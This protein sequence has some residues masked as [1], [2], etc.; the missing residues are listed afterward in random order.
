MASGLLGSTTK[1]PHDA[2]DGQRSPPHNWLDS[3]DEGSATVVAEAEVPPPAPAEP[4]H[5]LSS[6]AQL[7]WDY[8]LAHP[9]SGDALESCHVEYVA[10][11]LM[12]LQAAKK[13]TLTSQA[14][15]GKFAACLFI[16]VVQEILHF[17]RPTILGFSAEVIHR[18]MI[19]FARHVEPSVLI[20]HVQALDNEGAAYDTAIQPG[21]MDC[22]YRENGITDLLGT[23]D[24]A[25]GDVAADAFDQRGVQIEGTG[26]VV[27]SPPAQRSKLTRRMQLCLGVVLTLTTLYAASWSPTFSSD[28]ADSLSSNW[29]AVGLGQQGASAT[30]PPPATRALATLCIFGIHAPC[31]IHPAPCTAH[32]RGLSIVPCAMY[33]VPCTIRPARLTRAVRGPRRL[34][35]AVNNLAQL[36]IVVVSLAFLALMFPD[37]LDSREARRYIGI[38]LCVS[39]ICDTYVIIGVTRAYTATR[40]AAARVDDDRHMCLLIHYVICAFFFIWGVLYPT[41]VY[42]WMHNSWARLRS[43][44]V[45]DAAVFLTA[46]AALWYYGEDKFPPGDAPLHV[47]LLGRPAICLLASATFGQRNRQRL[48]AWG[49]RLGLFHV[50]VRASPVYLH[51]SPMRLPSL[52][53]VCKSVNL[54][55]P[56][57]SILPLSSL[58]DV[59][60]RIL[61]HVCQVGLNELR[62]GEIRRMLSKSGVGAPEADGNSALSDVFST[63]EDDRCAI[64]HV[65]PPFHGLRW[66]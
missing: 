49:A 36:L 20:Q 51:A 58:I 19:D 38:F 37:D 34:P 44:L 47:A 59:L 64:S 32:P 33:H 61:T 48:V 21:F 63:P 45:V 25:E 54:P 11:R 52:F 18:H 39:D 43:G 5:E 10:G 31:T 66:L 65:S 23:V 35:S 16:L 3:P 50:Q 42:F 27:A 9:L 41:A 24:E 46:I 7:I 62:R 29:I 53:H 15:S 30:D 60:S 40:S 57:I 1:Q 17:R 55:C 26:K 6:L 22:V 28:D 8:V 13:T 56:C 4:R 2:E 12:L 14:E